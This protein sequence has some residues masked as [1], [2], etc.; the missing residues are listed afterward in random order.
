MLFKTLVSWNFHIGASLMCKTIWHQQCWC[1]RFVSM[2]RMATAEKQ[3]RLY[4]GLKQIKSTFSHEGKHTVV[5][6]LSY[7]ARV[8]ICVSVSAVSA[9]VNSTVPCLWI[10]AFEGDLEAWR[11]TK[12]CSKC[13]LAGSPEPCHFWRLLLKSS[14]SACQ[15]AA[16]TAP[17][18][19]SRLAA[20]PPAAIAHSTNKEKA[21]HH[22]FA[23]LLRFELLYSFLTKIPSLEAPPSSAWY[24]FEVTVF[25]LHEDR[26]T[27]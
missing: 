11:L 23:L 17:S 26:D 10:A 25:R 16:P 4:K 5:D 2:W 20:W 24:L 21:P 27:A 19:R 1:C 7:S 12:C 13:F 18:E 3:W 6:K 8:Y 15:S 14:I 9:S 22:F